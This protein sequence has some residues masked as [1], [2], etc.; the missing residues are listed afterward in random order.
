MILISGCSIVVIMKLKPKD[1]VYVLKKE[2]PRLTNSSLNKV[3]RVKDVKVN[4]IRVS[5]DYIVVTFLAI[6]S[7]SRNQEI[8]IIQESNF[9]NIIIKEKGEI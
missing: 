6:L 1:I 4:G 3:F 9:K 7:M 8:E 2:F 5:K